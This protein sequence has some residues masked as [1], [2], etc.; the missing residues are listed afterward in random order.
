MFESMMRDAVRADYCDPAFHKKIWLAA[1][2]YEEKV[3]AEEK[4]GIKLGI[5]ACSESGTRNSDRLA[6]PES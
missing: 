3:Q 5:P 4:L 2:Q 1:L 6:I